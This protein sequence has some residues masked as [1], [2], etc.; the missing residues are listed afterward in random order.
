[1]IFYWVLAGMLMRLRWTLPE[2]D[3]EGP[4]GKV[5]VDSVNAITQWSGQYR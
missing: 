2:W 4:G 1:V 5:A 3:V